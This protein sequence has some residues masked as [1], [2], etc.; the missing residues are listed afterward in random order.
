MKTL[1]TLTNEEYNVLNKISS[2]TGMDCW[3]WLDETD[4]GKD[5]IHDLETD[6]IFS[7]KDG[8]ALLC[9]GLDCQENFDNCYLEDAEKLT[10]KELLTKL[11]ITV[12][13]D[14]KISTQ[15]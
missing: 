8:I 11:K 5:C 15:N 6:E 1:T 10:F 13:F 4:I 9:D 7:L 2:K 14:W 12:S 3:F